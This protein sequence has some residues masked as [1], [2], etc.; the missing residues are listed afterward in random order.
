VTS[1][2][3]L[4]IGEWKEPGMVCNEM[5]AGGRVGKEGSK[6]VGSSVVSVDDAV[7]LTCGDN[8]DITK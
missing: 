7:R 5:P 3:K 8:F 1:I 2:S 6:H 4:V